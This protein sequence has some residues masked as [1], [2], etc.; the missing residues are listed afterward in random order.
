MRPSQRISCHS[1]AVISECR[2]G[3]VFNIPEK[4]RN[5]TT[6]I[7]VTRDSSSNL[8]RVWNIWILCGI[9]HDGAL[10]A[11][12]AMRTASRS[13]H[14]GAPVRQRLHALLSGRGSTCSAQYSTES[15]AAGRAILGGDNDF[16]H[17]CLPSSRAIADAPPDGRSPRCEILIGCHSGS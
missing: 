3:S 17:N 6:A 5:T 10:L 8:R 13:H 12:D 4:F 14:S 15:A 16:N 7:L 2:H 1:Q 11:A 9:D